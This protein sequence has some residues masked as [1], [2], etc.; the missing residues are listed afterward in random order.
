MG[1]NNWASLRTQE[2]AGRWKERISATSYSRT[3]IKQLC[4]KEQEDSLGFLFVCLFFVCL[5]V[6]FFETG[7]LCITLAVLELTL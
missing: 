4:S 7:F 1:T 2:P 5:F 3:R 6:L